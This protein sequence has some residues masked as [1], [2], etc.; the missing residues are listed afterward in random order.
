MPEPLTPLTPS[1]GFGRTSSLR[2]SLPSSDRKTDKSDG[3]G[4]GGGG[5]APGRVSS[6]RRS[7]SMR[8]SRGSSVRAGDGMSSLHTPRAPRGCRN[9][10]LG[11]FDEGEQA[12]C[13]HP[14]AAPSAS[15]SLWPAL[16]LHSHPH[17]D[18][19]PEQAALVRHLNTTL[20]GD[21]DVAHLLRL[22]PWSDGVY[23]AVGSGVLLAK[24]VSKADPGAL[25]ARALN[26]PTLME[27]RTSGGDLG[28]GLERSISTFGRMASFRG[29]GGGGLT[30]SISSFAT[31]DDRGSSSV[32]SGGGAG[33]GGGGG[34]AGGGGGGGWELEEISE[35]AQLQ[36][37]TLCLNA[38][39]AIGAGVSGLAPSH[40]CE[41]MSHRAK[42]GSTPHA[43]VLLPSLPTAEGHHCP[44]HTQRCPFA[45]ARTALEPDTCQVQ[46]EDGAGATQARRRPLLP[47]CVARARR[48]RRG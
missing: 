6:F 13:P 30:R 33:A 21:R 22:D 19:A 32:Q 7:G 44:M 8:G 29:G 37:H 43:L 15:G 1:L 16:T 39:T 25:D 18:P 31:G 4:G 11:D 48:E 14:N 2:F 41:P 27:R 34:G 45:G 23:H 3:S 46:G 42:V 17:S 26:R 12:A 24:L 10:D 40:L 28:G 35:A 36:N 5:G 9:V 20:A 47:E 38:A